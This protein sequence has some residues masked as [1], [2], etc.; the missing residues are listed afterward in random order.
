MSIENI[1]NTVK[2][3]KPEIIRT[4]PEIPTRMEL[5][6]DTVKVTISRPV[7]MYDNGTAICRNEVLLI[8]K[9]DI[10]AILAKLYVE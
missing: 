1:E 7:K 3:T 10:K 8:P 9:N 6:G 4:K 2:Y 5:E